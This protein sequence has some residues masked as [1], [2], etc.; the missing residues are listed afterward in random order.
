MKHTRYYLL[1]NNSLDDFY[2]RNKIFIKID[3]TENGK[4]MENLTV[5]ARSTI[6]FLPVWKA[7]FKKIR[8]L[9]SFLNEMQWLVYSRV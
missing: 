9:P 8:K 7:Y 5:S 3:I 6:S 1:T 4:K 2:S